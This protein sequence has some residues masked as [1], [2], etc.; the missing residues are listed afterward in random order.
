M[1][2]LEGQ[3]TQ[4]I[5]SSEKQITFTQSV[6]CFTGS[7]SDPLCHLEFVFCRHGAVAMN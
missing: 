5:H 7:F 2:F 3:N 6:N 4:F 1:R